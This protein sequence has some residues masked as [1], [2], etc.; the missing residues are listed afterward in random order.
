MTTFSKH[1]GLFACAALLFGACAT[2]WSSAVD[3]GTDA[4]VDSTPQETDC[5]TRY[6]DGTVVDF[7]DSNFEAMVRDAILKPT[8]TMTYLDVKELGRLDGYALEI[9]DIDGVEYFTCLSHLDL[10]DNEIVDLSPLSDLSTLT[11]LYL[12]DNLIVDISPLGQLTNLTALDLDN[13]Q[14]VGISPLVTNAGIGTGDEVSLYG[15][16]LDCTDPNIAALEQRGV[17]L[18]IDCP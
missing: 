11:R 14:I 9:S 5:E 1:L 10:F 16:P 12:D 13:N 3:T 2:E 4:G 7:A 15:N 6:T 8:G 18:D 17:V